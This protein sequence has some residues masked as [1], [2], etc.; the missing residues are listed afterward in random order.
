MPRI[1]VGLG[2]PG[3]EYAWTRHNVGFQVVDEISSRLRIH[4]AAGQ[5]EYLV[6]G[7]DSLILVK[8]L[9]YMNNSGIAVVDLLNRYQVTVEELL[10]VVDDFALPLGTLR[11]RSRGT[12]G[13]HNGLRSIIYHLNSDNFPRLRCG[14]AKEPMPPKQDMADFVLSVF[15]KDEQDATR[16]M[17]KRAAD[18]CMAFSGEEIARLMNKY[19]M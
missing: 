10:V 1:I 4:L 5:G 8:P 18:A 7:V 19:N 16:D 2:N 14:I 3:S 17:V 12:D 15:D 13:G 6:A 11:I 9:T